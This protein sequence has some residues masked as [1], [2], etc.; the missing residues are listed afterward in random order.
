MKINYRKQFQDF[1]WKHI[2]LK[3]K[4][5]LRNKINELKRNQLLSPD[6]L[7]ELNWT[8]RKK[9]VEY[10]YEKVPYYYNRFKKE[11]FHPSDLN[12]PDDFEKIPLLTRKDIKNNLDELISTDFNKKNLIKLG[13]GGTTGAPIFVFKPINDNGLNTAIQERVFSWWNLR[14]YSDY[15][16]AYRIV[17]NNSKNLKTEKQKHTLGYQLTG[18]KK[19]FKHFVANSIQTKVSFDPSMISEDLMSS[20][21]NKIKKTSPEYLVGY[22]GAVYEIANYILQEKLNNVINIKAVWTT[23]A[24]LSLANRRIIEKAF[25]CPVF[26]QYG[27][28]EVFWMAAECKEHNGLH[29]FYDIRHIEFLDDNMR[30]VQN[31]ETGNVVITDLENYAFPIIRYVNGDRGSWKK[32]RCSCESNMPLINSIKGRQSDKIFLLNG[33]S[34]SG[35]F[36]TTIFDEFVDDVKNFQL[37]QEREGE[38]I[39]ALV[40]EENKSFESIKQSVENALNNKTKGALKLQFKMVRSIKHQNG[41]TK[42]IINKLLKN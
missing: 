15:A 19:S 27:S 23:A 26:D 20:F 33:S 39:I 3:K 25:N 5:E 34:V 29:F 13:T 32:G 6:A 4:P 35:E 16:T 14:P 17:K 12:S 41:K 37:I 9:I 40:L 38:L 8:K 30:Q 22:V 1:F 36:L 11:G 18:L 2:K 31:G 42:Y 24:P 28:I 10:A 7:K 21:I